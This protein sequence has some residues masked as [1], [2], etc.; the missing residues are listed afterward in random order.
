MG[1]MLDFLQVRIMKHTRSALAFA[2]PFV[3]LLV[4]T[5][6]CGAGTIINGDFSELDATSGL[7]M[8]WDHFDYAGTIDPPE[9]IVDG[10]NRY[11]R[12]HEQQQLEQ[13]F[14]LV[15]D[16]STLSFDFR[17]NQSGDGTT[18]VPPDSFQVTLYDENFNPLLGAP[19]GFFTID[20]VGS[21]FDSTYVTLSTL[22]DGWLRVVLDVSSLSPMSNVLLEFLVNGSDD[23]RVTMVDVDNVVLT[24]TPATSVIP[25]PSS[26]MIALLLGLSFFGIK[27]YSRGRM[28]SQ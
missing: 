25:E 27:R 26:A 24:S 21:Y 20:H 12:F 5:V 23:G 19:D 16:S 13:L 4:A 18:G 11:V 9:Y 10:D 2:W 3:V 1:L 8:G 28:A 15:L 22:T 7:P 17:W 14:N 6:P